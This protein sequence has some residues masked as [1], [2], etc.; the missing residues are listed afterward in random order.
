V[1]DARNLGGMVVGRGQD[2]FALNWWGSIE[3]EFV[4]SPRILPVSNIYIP[5]RIRVTLTQ[6]IATGL[7]QSA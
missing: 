2:A 1:K 4:V 6:V 7:M 5:N 3:F